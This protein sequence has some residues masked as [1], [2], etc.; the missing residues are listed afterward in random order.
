[1][2]RYARS[3]NCACGSGEYSEAVHDARGIFVAYVCSKCHKDK[4][5]GYRKDIFTDPRYWADETIEPE[6]Y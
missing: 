6:E 3:T 2:S 5:S 1:M 4:L